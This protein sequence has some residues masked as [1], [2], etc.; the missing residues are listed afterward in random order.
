MAIKDLF[1]E[2]VEAGWN[3]INASRLEKDLRI[4]ADVA[5]IGTGAGGGTA[6][7]ILA[8]AGLNVVMLEHGPLKT[9]NDFNMREKEAYRDLY[10]ESVSRLSEDGSITILQGQSVGG[11]TTV[12]WTSSFRTPDQT[13]EH[14]E[15]EFSVKGLS[16]QEMAPWFEMM[17]QRLG[18]QDWTVP[19]NQNNDALRRGCEELG[20]SWKTIPR[21]VKGCW[22]LGYCGTGC[23]TNAKQSMLVTTIPEALKRNASLVFLCEA[24]T[25]SLDQKGV[26]SLT[27]RAMDQTARVPTGQKVLVTA[28]H[29]VLSG[30]GINSP[31]LLMRSQAPDPNQLLGRRTFLHPTPMS[32]AR[33]REE[34]APYNGA[35]QSIYSDHFQWRNGT[36]GSMG[37]KLETAPLQPALAANLFAA[38]GTRLAERMSQLPYTQNM[39]A[40]LRDGFHEESQG[41]QVKIRK[42]GSPILDYTL[43]N[44]AWN[45]VRRA[46]LTMAEIQFAAGAESTLPLH[47]EADYVST[48][49]AA[50]KQIDH[51]SL[52]R[53]L[54]KIGSAHVMGGCAMSEDPGKGVVN[55]LGE[56]HQL[57]NLSVI[58][59]SVFPTSIGANPQL[60]VYGIAARFATHLAR[61]LGREPLL[62]A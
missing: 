22:N 42:D 19:P 30:G 36:T 23:P 8:R 59:G 24:E 16:S 46:L 17:E 6:A 38:R 50:R 1:A 14:W 9:S 15:K 12:N 29:Y 61:K 2:G 7:E 44:Y 5:I 43:T 25:F 37:F 31:A 11:S 51:L 56:H 39:L 58:D 32:M 34:V 18:I 53:Y 62:A 52:E 13:L 20:Y 3:I 40:L 60:S 21:N 4:E 41:G 48:M 35:P 10:Q 47:L 33:F 26:R 27:C 28:R 55:S 54:T 57:E 45:G 49:A